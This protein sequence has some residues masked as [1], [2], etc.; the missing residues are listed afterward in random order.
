[1]QVVG[2]L[3]CALIADVGSREPIDGNDVVHLRFQHR[4]ISLFSWIRE[5]KAA[6]FH[7]GII[8]GDVEIVV[9]VV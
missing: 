3:S 1:M 6:L 9:V 4:V 8:G 5:R 7:I 2:F